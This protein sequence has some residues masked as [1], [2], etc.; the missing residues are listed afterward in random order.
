M[1]TI[2]RK[3]SAHNDDGSATVQF[4]VDGL[5]EIAWW[6]LGYSDQVQIIA[7]AALRNKVLN[8]AQNM[9]RLNSSRYK[10]ARL[11]LATPR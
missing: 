7:P 1:L 5:G 6:I 10:A 11:R 2:W 3:Y 4:R 9:V 8:A